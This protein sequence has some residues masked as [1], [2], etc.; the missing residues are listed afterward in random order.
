MS[1]K[2]VNTT[3]KPVKVEN[4]LLN[5][6]IK[7]DTDQDLSIIDETTENDNI[8]SEEELNDD[9]EEEINDN[10]EED[11][12]SSEADIKSV[13]KEICIYDNA[14][15]EK[16]S[17]SE[18]DDVLVFDDENSQENMEF[19]EADRRKTPKKLFNY[20]KVRLLGDRTK[21]L[22]LG[23]KPMIKNTQNMDAKDIALLELSENLI[24][25]IL[26]RELPSGKKEK[27]YMHELQH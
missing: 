1:K 17:D 18:E 7:K 3:K 14:P 26:I 8:D 10:E 16:N 4:T 12:I 2:Q 23:A 15:N 21:Q 27:W 11:E 25:L 6:L 24:P 9:E 19:V 20:E 13:D 22:T 5:E